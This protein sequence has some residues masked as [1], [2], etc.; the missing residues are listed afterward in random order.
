M[1][2]KTIYEQ[3]LERLEKI[4]KKFDAGMEGEWE[5]FQDTDDQ[6]DSRLIEANIELD[7]LID[8]LRDNEDEDI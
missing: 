2:N 8:E 4:Q 7:E 3:I 5:G 1:E 6:P